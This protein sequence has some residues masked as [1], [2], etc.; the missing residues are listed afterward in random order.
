M[1][2]SFDPESGTVVISAGTDNS[3][4][5]SKIR[6]VNED[7]PNPNPPLLF[8][9]NLMAA[10]KEACQ[11]PTKVPECVAQIAVPDSFN[12]ACAV[13]RNLQDNSFF[14]LSDQEFWVLKKGNELTGPFKYADIPG[15]KQTPGDF[16][17]FQRTMD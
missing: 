9:F 16:S 17:S 4:S 13:H 2:L 11:D 14:L 8:S 6:K 1:A 10:V 12:S 3:S 7:T 5:I 15:L